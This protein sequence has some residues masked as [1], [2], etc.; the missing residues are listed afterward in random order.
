MNSNIMPFCLGKE[1]VDSDEVVS[2]A[3]DIHKILK[4]W[5][6]PYKRRLEEVNDQDYKEGKIERYIVLM[7]EM[8]ITIL[9][10]EKEY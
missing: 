6:T 10:L 5:E 8:L 1:F 7:S 4:L 9:Y 2:A 3:I